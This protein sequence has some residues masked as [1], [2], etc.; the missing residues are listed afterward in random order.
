MDDQ[1]YTSPAIT[2]Y[3]SLTELTADVNALSFSAGA[4]RA[5]ASFAVLSAPS[6]LVPTDASDGATLGTSNTG[7]GGISPSTGSDPGA[8]GTLGEAVPGGGGTDPGGTAGSSGGTSGVAAEARAG[9]AA[10][11]DACPSRV[12]R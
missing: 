8:S 12:S 1:I 5:V 6:V 9:E 3:G 2:D 10:V 11:T 7:G 4:I